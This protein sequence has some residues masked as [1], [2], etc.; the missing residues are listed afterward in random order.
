MQYAKNAR[1]PQ[2]PYWFGKNLQYALDQ[3]TSPTVSHCAK[4]WN[5]V[6]TT[7]TLTCSYSNLITL[8]I[9]LLLFTCLCRVSCCWQN[10]VC[11]RY[12]AWPS[13]SMHRGEELP[14][15][16][17]CNVT[18]SGD[19]WILWISSVKTNMHQQP[20]ISYSSMILFCWQNNA[21]KVCFI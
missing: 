5:D 19:T 10:C 6:T 20:R 14:K 9:G 11:W 4:H 7:V 12:G 2:M 8:V 13:E 15:S 21:I 17:T 18:V 16:L 3:S 1:M